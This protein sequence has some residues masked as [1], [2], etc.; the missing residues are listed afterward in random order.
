M[1]TDTIRLG[2]VG[3]GRNTRERHIPGFKAIPGVE[4]VSV[5][6]RSRESGER[7][8]KEFGISKV[9]D[10]WV[11]LINADDTT[12][13]CIG[14]WPYMHCT[15]TLAA[16]EANKHVI[17]EARM[18]MNAAEAHTMLAAARRKPYLVT[19]IV[20]SPL[21]LRV[22]R[23][24]RDLLADGYLGDILSI[25]VRS[26]AEA[27]VDKASP[28]H[29]RQDR[30][31]SGYNILNMGIW[32]EALMRWH[33]L[34]RKSLLDGIIPGDWGKIGSGWLARSLGKSEAQASG[35]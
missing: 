7:V 17:T 2:M 16:L 5:A 14:T 29:W 20:P 8:A 26:S 34:R 30:D 28:L 22:D 25:E 32:Y 27:F 3:A 13:I 11:D 9:Y 12:A 35:I 31:L 4:L 10:H 33:G 1:S 6:N 24:V 18:A 21:T 19:Q 23:T 15:L